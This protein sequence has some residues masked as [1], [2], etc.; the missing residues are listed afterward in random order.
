MR[1][2]RMLI[3]PHIGMFVATTVLS[4]VGLGRSRLLYSRTTTPMGVVFLSTSH[5]L[6]L[7]LALMRDL[8]WA[9]RFC[10]QDKIVVQYHHLTS[11]DLTPI[12]RAQLRFQRPRNRCRRLPRPPH[13]WRWL[14]RNLGWLL[15]HSVPSIHAEGG[16]RWKPVDVSDEQYLRKR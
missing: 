5:K 14:W 11:T 13:F 16:R 4:S 15:D 9:V 10:P 2:V 1:P 12:C 7:C 6:F 3:I 8:R